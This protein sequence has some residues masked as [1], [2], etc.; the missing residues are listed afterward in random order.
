LCGVPSI[1]LAQESLNELSLWRENKR[2]ARSD[3]RANRSD[4]AMGNEE[5]KEACKSWTH[6]LSNRDRKPVQTKTS[7][8]MA[9]T[10]HDWLSSSARLQVI[11]IAGRKRLVPRVESRDP[12][13][14]I[15][16]W[17]FTCNRGF[18]FA[19]QV[20]S[21]RFVNEKEEE[22]PVVNVKRTRICMQR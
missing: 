16:R 12:V 2:K 1:F 13:S 17:C 8:R 18:F 19:A 14:C 20:T 3:E 9:P 7:P 4:L 5:N 10:I 15:K 22:S 6:F 21:C 11:V